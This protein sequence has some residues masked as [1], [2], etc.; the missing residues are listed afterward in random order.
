MIDLEYHWL[1]PAEKHKSDESMVTHV[2]ILAIQTARGIS[3]NVCTINGYT[4][5]YKGYLDYQAH[6]PSK[7]TIHRS[8]QCYAA[9][10]EY[11]AIDK[12]QLLRNLISFQSEQWITFWRQV[13]QHGWTE[14]WNENWA[15]M[16]CETRAMTR[17]ETQ[18]ISNQDSKHSRTVHANKPASWKKRL[19]ENLTRT[20]TNSV[21]QLRR[22]ESAIQVEKID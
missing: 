6:E 3:K 14:K 8:R 18:A 1:E 17:C 4:Q 21:E 7:Y 11:T 20:I 16:G 15:M 10:I 13:L 9:Y 12:T 19:N 2:T 22:N 5:P